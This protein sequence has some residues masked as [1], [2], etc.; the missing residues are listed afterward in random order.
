MLD[1]EACYHY[2]VAALHPEG[3]HCPLG[4]PLPPD[5]APHRR[6]RAPVVDYRCRVC[7]KVFNAFS[8]TLWSKTKYRPSIIVQILKGVAQ[9]TP[10]QHLAWEL[11][12]DRSTL[13][14]RRQQIQ[15]QLAANFPL[16][17]TK[18]GRRSERSG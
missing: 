2:L 5:Q 8:G 9:G 15:A 6:V 12:I 13:T 7:G 4:H 18:A 14:G 17:P 3:L 16:P 10:T 1:E 11:K